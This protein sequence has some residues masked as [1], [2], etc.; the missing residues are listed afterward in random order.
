MPDTLRDTAPRA[1]R[2]DIERILGRLDPPVM[3]RIVALRPKVEDV[4]L[5]RMYLAGASDVMGEDRRPLTGVAREV[6]DVISAEQEADED[7]P[8]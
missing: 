3:A 1:L 2:A 7:E 5:A 8:F 6:Y 4:E